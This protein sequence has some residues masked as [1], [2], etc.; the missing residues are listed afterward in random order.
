MT[1]MKTLMLFAA[2][3]SILPGQSLSPKWEELTAADFA[4]AIKQANFSCVLPFG[5]LE[6]HGP[7]GPIGTDL[8]DV[9][10]ITTKAVQKEYALVFPE[11][12]VGQIF[13]ARH[14]P[15][16]IACSSQLQLQMLQETVSEMGRNGCRKILIA[17]GHGG[18]THLMASFFATH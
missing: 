3:A 16:A 10:Y 4:K 17:S 14:Q 2:F 11:Y 7:S 13:E 18:A 12:Y 15:G 8:I 1:L 9:R 5:I 6:K